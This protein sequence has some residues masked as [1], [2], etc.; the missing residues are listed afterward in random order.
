EGLG[1]SV[2]TDTPV[3]EEATE[4]A[5]EVRMAILLAEAEVIAPEHEMADTEEAKV[6]ADLHLVEVTNRVTE[7]DPRVEATALL[8]ALLPTAAEAVATVEATVA[9]AEAVEEEDTEVVVE[10]EAVEGVTECTRNYLQL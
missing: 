4:G 2:M 9:T 7:A 5:A 10:V 8:P 3:V 1:E 6:V